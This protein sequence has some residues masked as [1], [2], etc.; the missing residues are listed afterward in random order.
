MQLFNELT[1]KNFEKSLKTLEGGRGRGRSN[2]GNKIS[3]PP[4]NLNVEKIVG[5]KVARSL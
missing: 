4:R 1:P 5:S 2:Q 3:S